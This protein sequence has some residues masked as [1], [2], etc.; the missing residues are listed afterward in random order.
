MNTFETFLDSWSGAFGRTKVWVGLKI[1][2]DITKNSLLTSELNIA[3][4]ARLAQKLVRWVVGG[5]S[6]APNGAKG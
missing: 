5:P 6:P 1:G 4:Y 2:Y 3:K